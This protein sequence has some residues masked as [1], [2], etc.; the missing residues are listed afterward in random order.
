MVAL[1]PVAGASHGELERIVPVDVE[2]VE[3]ILRSSPPE[4]AT[5]FCQPKMKDASRI[6]IQ[7][8][9]VMPFTLPGVDAVVSKMKASNSSFHPKRDEGD[10]SADVTFIL[11]IL[12]QMAPRC[13]GS[14]MNAFFA[15][16]NGYACVM[17]R[18]DCYSQKMEWICKGMANPKDGPATSDK[19]TPNAKSNKIKVDDG[20]GYT[21][22]C[23]VTCDLVI[24]PKGVVMGHHIFQDGVLTS[25]ADPP[26]GHISGRILLCVG[27]RARWCANGTL[28][29]TLPNSMFHVEP[30]CVPEHLGGVDGGDDGCVLMIFN[31]HAVPS[32]EVAINR[33]IGNIISLTLASKGSSK[34]DMANNNAEVAL[35]DAAKQQIS[36]QL[37]METIHSTRVEMVVSLQQERASKIRSLASVIHLPLSLSTRV[38]WSPLLASIID[39]SEWRLAAKARYDAE[40]AK[41]FAG[42]NELREEE[43]AWN[44]GVWEAT[45]SAF[46]EANSKSLS[47]GLTHLMALRRVDDSIVQFRCSSEVGQAVALLKHR[48]PASVAIADLVNSSKGWDMHRLLAVAGA[49]A[50]VGVLVRVQG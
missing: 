10:V 40:I 12:S 39:L 5:Y 28:L 48:S 20:N 45:L 23:F 24:I 13:D 8:P 41:R 16:A 31:C 37:S 7:V 50:V 34:K 26:L 38:R 9:P 2:D 33:A 11:S 17:R 18:I 30:Q 14:A 4:A 1:F 3:E 29:T 21:R 47:V 15:T 22:N 25:S 19:N 46:E 42:G 27:G 35:L 44:D 32:L 36:Q 43:S 49:L 6:A